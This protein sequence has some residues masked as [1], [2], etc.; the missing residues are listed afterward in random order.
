MQSF[1]GLT[2]LLRGL[3]GQRGW[4]PQ[5]RSPEPRAEYDALIVG[6]GGHGLGAAYYLASEHRLTNIAV[7]EP[8]WIGGGNTGRNTTI[9]RAN[10]LRV[11]STALYEHALNIRNDLA[12]ALHYN[13]CL[14]P[15]AVIML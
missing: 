3:T 7:L 1:S 9:I 15:R 14:S 4:T 11:E 5:W 13:L 2:L 8:G 12:Q 6:G 10:Y